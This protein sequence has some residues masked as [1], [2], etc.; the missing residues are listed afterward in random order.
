MISLPSGSLL[1]VLQEHMWQ[2]LTNALRLQACIQRKFSFLCLSLS[3]RG[4]MKC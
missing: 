3:I 1:T 2:Y 4:T